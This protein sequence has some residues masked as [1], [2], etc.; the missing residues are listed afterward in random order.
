MAVLT[1]KKNIF[2]SK[3]LLVS[4]LSTTLERETVDTLVA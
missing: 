4:Q 2:S 1:S 3:M